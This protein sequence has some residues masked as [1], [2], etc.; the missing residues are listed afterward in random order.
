YRLSDLAHPIAVD[1]LNDTSIARLAADLKPLA[2]SM[3]RVPLRDGLRVA[4]GGLAEL[5]GDTAKVAHLVSD[6]RAVDWS[7]G[8]DGLK[9][10]AGELGA[11]K[12]KLNLVD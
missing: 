11:A 1:R 7:E 5:P 8:A 4:Q 6:F 10:V 9:E 3:V 12:V 2:P